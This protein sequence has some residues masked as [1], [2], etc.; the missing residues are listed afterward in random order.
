M[1]HHRRIWVAIS[2]VA[3]GLLLIGC[4]A[5]PIPFLS[6]AA[7]TAANTLVYDAPVT[8]TIRTGTVWSGTTIAYLGK[9]ATGSAKVLIANQVAEKQMG[10]TVDWQGTPAPDTTV[11][12][13][14]RVLSFDDQGV[15]LLGT[16]HIEIAK[17]AIVSGNLPTNA[18]ME[19]SAPATYSLAKNAL[20]PGSTV[21]YVGAA[22]EGAQFS[23]IQGYPYR[24]TLDSLEYSGQLNPKVFLKLDLRVINFSETGA[25]LGG[26]AT[27][28]ILP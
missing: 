10:D 12:L 9:G 11:R 6:S 21:V 24:K 5:L 8:T 23:G 20:V 26:T 17:T 1:D 19:F 3:V 16:A 25:I 7:P 18:Q 15:T 28:K 13:S 22:S 2:V 4:N 27:I 14:T